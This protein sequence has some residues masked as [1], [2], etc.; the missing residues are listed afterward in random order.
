[1]S[2]SSDRLPKLIS[3]V[4]GAMAQRA[5]SRQMN[6]ISE[7]VL[8]GRLRHGQTFL[9]M[10]GIER[11]ASVAKDEQGIKSRKCQVLLSVR[12]HPLASLLWRL[13]RASAIEPGLF[14]IHVLATPPYHQRRHAEGEA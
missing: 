13:R 9:R 6:E 12:V 8:A 5:V 7:P 2:R 3:H 4:V 10:I 1:M 11:L 14:E